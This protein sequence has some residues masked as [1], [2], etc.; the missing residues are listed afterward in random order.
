MRDDGD[1]YNVV[2]GSLRSLKNKARRAVFPPPPGPVL[3]GEKQAPAL[4]G[5]PNIR[6]A[7]SSV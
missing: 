3:E 6:L 7:L 1:T 4:S 5:T 2:P